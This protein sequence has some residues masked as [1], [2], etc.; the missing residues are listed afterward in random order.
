MIYRV[1]VPL[2]AMSLFFMEPMFSLFSPIE[3]GGRYYTL[4]PY[5]FA[6]FLIL[7]TAYDTQKTAY[8][9]A[10]LFGIIYDMYHIDLIG[11]YTFIYPFVVLVA[12]FVIERVHREFSVVLVLAIV[13]IMSIEML[14]FGFATA[15]SFT[16]MPFRAF[17]I[18]RLLPTTLANGLFIIL[19]SYSLR[20]FIEKR[21]E[22]LD[23]TI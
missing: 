23:P 16:S 21:R 8:T 1:L 18:E 17:A 20:F 10:F 19:F 2:I 6:T 5:F 4:I 15:V 22:A 3:W 13:L 9:Y 14:S 7:L 12:T 11:V